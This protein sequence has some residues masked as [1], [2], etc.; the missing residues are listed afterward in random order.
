LK[1]VIDPAP[2]AL[3]WARLGGVEGRTDIASIA[4]SWEPVKGKFR[5]REACSYEKGL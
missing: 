2:S 4:K 3:R 1:L 5:D